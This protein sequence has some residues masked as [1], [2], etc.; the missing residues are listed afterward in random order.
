MWRKT[1]EFPDHPL[2]LKDILEILQRC[3]N[4]REL[5]EFSGELL[6]SL[7]RVQSCPDAYDCVRD[8]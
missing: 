3:L 7:H 6:G 1:I 5:A 2:N 8:G 4:E